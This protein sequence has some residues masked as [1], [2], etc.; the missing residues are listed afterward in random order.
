MAE[1]EKKTYEAWAGL[2][3]IGLGLLLYL[4]GLWLLP[5]E[6]TTQF[7]VDGAYGAK[8]PKALALLTPLAITAGFGLAYHKDPEKSL[9]RLMLSAVGLVL[10]LLTFFGNL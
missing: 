2:L 9:R 8:V 6:I 4:L 10:Y 5:S 1:P 3:M 7:Q